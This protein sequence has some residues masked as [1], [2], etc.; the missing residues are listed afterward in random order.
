MKLAAW[1]SVSDLV[2]QQKTFFEGFVLG[3]FIK[4]SIFSQK[5]P[6]EVL[7]TLK[8]SGVNGIE[9]LLSSNASDNDL[10]RINQMIRKLNMHIFSI[11]QPLSILF[12]IKISKIENLCQ[13][14][15][16]LGAKVLVLHINVIGNQIFD[17]E[18]NRAVKTLEKKYDIEI[19]IENSPKSILTIFNS[20]CWQENKFSKLIRENDLNITFDTTHL[21]QAAAASDSVENDIINFYKNNKERIVN[22]HLSDYKKHFL[23]THLFLANYTHLPLDSGQL[24]I[25]E[26]LQILKQT[27]YD[28]L[29]TM[30]INGNLEELCKS[31][32]FIKSIVSPI[33]LL[34]QLLQ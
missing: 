13:I 27:N 30:E 32:E 3:K 7:L 11:H 5:N 23:N 17:K 9:L 15:K 10:E 19:G 20:Y 2:P 28:G 33:H 1:V 12:D 22:I 25:K 24:P 4:Q 34:S 21:A 26:F 29:I 31:A 16:K 14:A 18:Y 8:K 6:S